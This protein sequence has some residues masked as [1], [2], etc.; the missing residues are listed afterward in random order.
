MYGMGTPRVTVSDRLSLLHRARSG[1]VHVSAVLS[2]RGGRLA[3][4]TVPS[5]ALIGSIAWM[6]TLGALVS[7]GY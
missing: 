2:A 3:A 6:Q 1:H 4:V 5:V 7:E